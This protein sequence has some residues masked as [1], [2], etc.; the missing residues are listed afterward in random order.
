MLTRKSDTEMK[1]PEDTTIVVNPSGEDLSLKEKTLLSKGLLFCPTPTIL[2]K[3]QL[4]DDLESFFRCIHLK[5]FFLD[6]DE[7]YHEEAE[8]ERNI[9]HPPSN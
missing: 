9:F 4:L 7:E 5:E 1:P 8:E 6:S 3:D 2:D